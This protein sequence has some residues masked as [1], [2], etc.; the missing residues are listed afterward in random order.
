MTTEPLVSAGWLLEHLGD[1]DVR[2]VDVRWYLTEPGRG[3][4]E[5]E[6]GHILGAAYM[7]IDTD[8]SAP[9]GSGPGR[10][11]LPSA[12][13]FAAAAGRAGIGADT[14][15][16]AYDA[17]GGA[18]AAR[19]WWLLRYFGH[20]RVSLLDGGWQA[21]QAAGGPVAAGVVLVE[22]APFEAR[23]HPEMVVGAA[24]V[25]EL[26]RDPR[27]L[28]LD[29]RAAERYEGRVEPI[30]PRAGHIPGAVSAPFGGNLRPDGTLL[31][32]DELRARY[33]ALG[34]AGAETVVCYC[35]SGVTAAHNVL[36][37]HLAGR[38]ALLYEGSWS[39]WSSDPARPA[40]TGPER[41]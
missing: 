40:A 13:A 38:D 33:D 6:A 11:P 16:V 9:K 19:L 37:L 34:V 29:A 17:A 14:H 39:D 28:V 10:H 2:V 3:R 36:A 20:A 25:D 5:Y 26:R 12:E 27:A 15:V 8:L 31:G 35:G 1:P 24:A 41:G 18:Y 22:P 30:D 7:D 21:W 32:A 4:A 23:P